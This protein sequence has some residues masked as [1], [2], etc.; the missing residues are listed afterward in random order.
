M[1]VPSGDGGISKEKKLYE[2]RR[3]DRID[4]CKAHN[5]NNRKLLVDP[6]R[7]GVSPRI[8]QGSTPKDPG[9]LVPDTKI[10]W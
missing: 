3:K 6:E 2:K 5:E 8:V 1:R 7:V 10:L 9:G 4:A